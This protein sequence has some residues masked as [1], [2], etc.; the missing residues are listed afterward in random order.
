MT[1]ATTFPELLDN[2]MFSSYIRCGELFRSEF[3]EQLAPAAPNIHL[4]AGGA[5]ASGLEKAR[6]AFYEEGTSSDE[7]IRR[8]LEEIIRFYGPLELPPARTGDKSCDNVLRAFSS[9]MERYPFETA[10]IVPFRTANGRCMIEFTFSIP[11]EIAH[12]ETGNPLLYGGR[13]DMIGVMNN[14][15]WVTDEKTASSLGEQWRTQWDLDSQFTGYIKA[16]KDY[17]YPVAG[18]LV[19]GVGLLK[20][21]ITHEEALI[22]RASWEIER[23]WEERHE[24]ARR[25][26]SDWREGRFIHAL[27]KGACAA[28]GGCKFKLLCAV[29]KTERVKWIPEHYRHRVWNPLEKDAGE[30]LLENPEMFKPLVPPDLD[31]PDLIDVSKVRGVTG[32]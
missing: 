1:A 20:T 13:S 19:R 16:A 12:P 7:A 22:Y 11:M 28:Y 26:I 5:F 9:Y 24:I 27:D 15:L 25:M 17:G 4:H 10:A 30:H 6:R 14:V 32:G 2:T 8:G 23:W 18:A 31:I 21:K 29:P 3:L